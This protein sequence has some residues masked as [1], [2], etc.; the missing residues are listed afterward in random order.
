[1]YMFP[2]MQILWTCSFPLIT[3]IRA[4][5]FH[6]TAT[7][8]VSL[9]TDTVINEKCPS[10]EKGIFQIAFPSLSKWWNIN[11]YFSVSAILPF[12][13]FL[14]WSNMLFIVS[15]WTSA[16]DSVFRHQH[17]YPISIATIT[18]SIHVSIIIGR[19]ASVMAVVPE[20]LRFRKYMLNHPVKRRGDRGRNGNGMGSGLTNTQC[21]PW[22]AGECPYRNLQV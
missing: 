4:K 14:Q 21:A 10:A 17:T 20:N 2:L 9:L 11:L 13:G 12:R 16:D 15:P 3:G 5:F 22:N 1:M 6:G 19:N 8:D 7:G 18:R